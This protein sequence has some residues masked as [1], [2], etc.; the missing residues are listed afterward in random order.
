MTFTFMKYVT[1]RVFTSVKFVNTKMSSRMNYS[2]GIT[3]CRL[4]VRSAFFQSGVLSGELRRCQYGKYRY[5]CRYSSVSVS[6]LSANTQLVK[7]PG[8]PCLG[9]STTGY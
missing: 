7:M 5:F 2:S 9:I 1:D 3:D 6:I 8:P 4:T